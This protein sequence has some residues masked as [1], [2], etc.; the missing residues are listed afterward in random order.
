MPVPR[1]VN[2][3]ILLDEHQSLIN[4]EPSDSR[5]ELEWLNDSNND[6]KDYLKLAIGSFGLFEIL[7]KH[8]LVKNK[9]YRI[10]LWD[11]VRHSL[12]GI[13][14]NFDYGDLNK[15]CLKYLDKARKDKAYNKSLVEQIHEFL[16]LRL[17]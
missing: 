9:K 16:K 15:L 7:Q 12:S 5:Q 11:G 14:P 3:Q 4:D 10:R 17:D 1:I 13:L 8:G 6:P 2:K